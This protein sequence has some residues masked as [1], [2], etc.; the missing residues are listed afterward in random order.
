MP[1]WTQRRGHSTVLLLYTKNTFALYLTFSWVTLSLSLC[2]EGYERSIVS[3]VRKG[4]TGTV[5]PVHLET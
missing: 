2:Y 4:Y 1:A 5:E 3:F